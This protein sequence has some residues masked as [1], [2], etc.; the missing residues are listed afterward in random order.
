MNIWIVSRFVTAFLGK[1]FG[2]HGALLEEGNL[3]LCVTKPREIILIGCRFFINR[4]CIAEFSFL[5]FGVALK[6]MRKAFIALF[7]KVLFRKIYPMTG[8]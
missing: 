6:V 1:D 3:F 8:H 4:N 2:V 5:V 7:Y